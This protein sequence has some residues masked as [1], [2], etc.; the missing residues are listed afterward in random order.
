MYDYFVHITVDNIFKHNLLG[1]V[2]PLK[3]YE[4]FFASWNKFFPN[5]PIISNPKTSAFNP[6]TWNIWS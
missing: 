5:I 1:F 4:D 3:A 6:T 2:W